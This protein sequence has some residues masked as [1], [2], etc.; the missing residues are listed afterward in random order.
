[1]DVVN[2]LSLDARA[3][4]VGRPFFWGLSSNGADGVRVMLEILRTDFERAPAYSGAVTTKDLDSGLVNP[5][6][7]RRA[8]GPVQRS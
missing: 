3:V 2:A 1:M 5:P 6:C 7:P 4:L 8:H